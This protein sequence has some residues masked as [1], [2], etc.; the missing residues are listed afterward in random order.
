[1]CVRLARAGTS[2]RL[3]IVRAATVNHERQL[4][5]VC[6]GHREPC[7][8]C[9][10]LHDRYV[11]ATML[12]V[13]MHSLRP[14]RRAPATGGYA[15]HGSPQPVCVKALQCPTASPHRGEARWRRTHPSDVSSS[16]SSSWQLHITSTQ[17]CPLPIYTRIAPQ[18]TVES[19][20]SCTAPAPLYSVHTA[21]SLPVTGSPTQTC[22]N[23]GTPA[24]AARA[25]VRR[26]A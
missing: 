19:L 24:P 13:D 22:S 6:P 15:E 7:Q 9:C 11:G 21:T 4:V 3:G 2:P 1:M 16:I 12:R 10:S 18:P 5:L 26:C 8:R 20:L 25:A 23:R 17:P 14:V